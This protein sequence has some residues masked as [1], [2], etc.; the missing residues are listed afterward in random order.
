MN[1]IEYTN[2]PHHNFGCTPCI[3]SIISKFPNFQTKQTNISLVSYNVAIVI[4]GDWVNMIQ[5]IWN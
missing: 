2:F 3:V 5:S 4:F 1:R